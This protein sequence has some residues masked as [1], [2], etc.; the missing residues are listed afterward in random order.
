MASNG[1]GLYESDSRS[2]FLIF[3]QTQPIP[4]VLT[5]T[6]P[7]GGSGRGQLPSVLGNSS[8][9]NFYFVKEPQIFSDFHILLIL[10]QLFWKMHDS[11]F[12]FFL[13]IIFFRSLNA[14]YSNP[15]FVGYESV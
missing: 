6:N 5:E 14:Y 10:I 7:D 15:I 9:L 4:E 13:L 11:F 8:C 12:F 2:S 3:S 1:A